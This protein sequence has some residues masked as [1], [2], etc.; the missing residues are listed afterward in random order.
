MLASAV[1]PG[2]SHRHLAVAVVQVE[3]LPRVRVVDHLLRL[4]ADVRHKPPVLPHV[5]GVHDSREDQT[6]GADRGAGDEDLLEVLGVA[7]LEKRPLSYHLKFVVA[8]YTHV[9]EKERPDDHDAANHAEGDAQ[10]EEDDGHLAGRG[11]ARRVPPGRGIIN[12]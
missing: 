11:A 7:L 8:P 9:L 10:V 5:D 1:R 6:D 3:P 2:R 12:H 4:G